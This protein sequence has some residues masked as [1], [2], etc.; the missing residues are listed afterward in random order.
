MTNES[1]RWLLMD[2]AS[3]AASYIEQLSARKVGPERRAV[4]RLRAAPVVP[5]PEGPGRA[6]D[7]LAF[8]D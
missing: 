2:A 1:V 7:V 4:E 6:T 8:V 3:R 5:L